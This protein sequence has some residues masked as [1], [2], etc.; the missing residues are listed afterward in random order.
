[1]VV[2]SCIGIGSQRVGGRSGVAKVGRKWRNFGCA[3]SE[4]RTVGGAP[5]EHC[6]TLTRTGIGGT[7]RAVFGVKKEFPIKCGPRKSATVSWQFSEQE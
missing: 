1:M 4:S 3:A 5:D 6:F 7:M 2:R